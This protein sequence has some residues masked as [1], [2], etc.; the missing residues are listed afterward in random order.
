MLDPAGSTEDAAYEAI[1]SRSAHEIIAERFTS[2]Q[3]LDLLT[4]LRDHPRSDRR[5]AGSMA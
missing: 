5:P 4:G 3:A 1:R 2:E